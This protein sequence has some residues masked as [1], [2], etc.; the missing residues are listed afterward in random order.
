[1]P[2]CSPATSS[3]TV[4]DSQSANLTLSIKTTA[5]T[6]AALTHPASGRWY[7]TASFML[8]GV[9]LFGARGKRQRWASM[10]GL[11]VCLVALGTL[12]GCGG[13]GSKTGGSSAGGPT[14][15][16]SGTPGTTAD[17]YT[18][19]IRATDVATGT[20]TAE[21]DIQFVIE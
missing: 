20:L 1:M 10:L 3:L 8:A 13:G 15:G 19:A 2:T 4:T 12:V 9:V 5:P 21:T 11:V 6:S 14:S 17:T 7:A 16:S 18:I